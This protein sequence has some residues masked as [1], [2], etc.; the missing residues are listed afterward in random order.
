MQ[1]SLG[2]SP[3]ELVFGHSVR[4]P[5]KLLKEN[6][7]DDGESTLN[8]LDYVSK[9]RHKLKRA[10]ELAQ[11]NL[12][13]SQ[14]KMKTLDQHAQSQVFK[15]GD[16]VL[17][18]L[19][20]MGNTL[21]ARYH[22]PY[23]ILNKVGEVDYIVKTPDRRKST[24][25]CHINMIKPYY[26]R[27]TCQS[28]MVVDNSPIAQNVHNDDVNDRTGEIVEHLIKLSNSEVLAN[29]DV[30]LAHLSDTQRSDLSSLLLKYEGIFPDVPNKTTAAVH[31]VEV[32]DASPIKQ[33]PYRVNPSKLEQMRKEVKYMLDND[34]IEPSQSNWSSPCV[35]VPKPD[36]SIRFCTDFRKVNSIT[37]TDSFPI[38]RMEDCIDRIGKAQFI[39][40][41]DLLKGYWCVPMSQRAKE[42]SA[43]V[44][45]DSLYQYKVMPYGMKN[46]Q[47]T[48]Q[49]MMNNCLRDLPGVEIYVDDIVVYSDT[50]EEH[51]FRLDKMFDRLKQANLTVNLSK[52]DFGKAQVVYLG[53]VIGHGQVTPIEAKVKNILE[54]PIPANKRSLMRFLGMAGY[55]RK[56]CKN[57]SEVAVPL[58]N[59]L[60]K[61]VKYVWSENCQKSFENLKSLLCSK[62]VLAAPD[63]GKP[64]SIAVDASDL[65]A[66]AVLLQ[67]DDDGVEHPVSYYSK[68]F[69]CQQKNYSTIEKE[70]LGL[71]LALQHFDVYVA[72]TGQIVT[73]YTDHNPLV[74]LN[75]MKNKNRRL[76]SWSLLLQ[77]YTLDIKHIRGIDN[78]CADALSQ[79]M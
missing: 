65:G 76:L 21:K 47:A 70:A 49:R 8:L 68:K 2:F 61:N 27:N 50:W 75:K 23:E 29:L 52:S 5:L 14:A 25:L 78:I 20:L 16:K 3:F 77:E 63:F 42:I 58:T 59:L 54:Y 44:T 10:C 22:G 72:S 71:V 19:P 33:H 45:P 17:V 12:K 4:G 26:D 11:E 62:P 6:W 38:P 36:G 30:K 53:H 46:S 56:F 69:N 24:Q 31:D 40:K 37:K 67:N 41:C 13:V 43:F 28:V 15:P 7:L 39:T 60:K 35:M 73:V 57:F 48:F 66:G 55:Y 51:M 64:F 34:I 32:G 18:M 74:F 79:A 1:E 9:F